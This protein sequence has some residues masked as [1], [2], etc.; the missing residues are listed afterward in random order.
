MP[1][2]HVHSPSFKR[3]IKFDCVEIAGDL[4]EIGMANEA[5]MAVVS[6]FVEGASAPRSI[7]LSKEDMRRLFNWLGVELHR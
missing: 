4:M 7:A 6:I 2:S 5:D 3:T 1:D